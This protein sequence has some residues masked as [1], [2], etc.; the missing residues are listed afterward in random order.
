MT[1]LEFLIVEQLLIKEFCLVLE[2]FSYA[3][4]DHLL[5]VIG[6]NRKVLKES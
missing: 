6:I 3:I 1:V 5:S 2:H 4:S